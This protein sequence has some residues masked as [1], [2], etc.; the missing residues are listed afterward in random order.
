M[1]LRSCHRRRG[2]RE[3]LIVRLRPALVSFILLF[4]AKSDEAL[5]CEGVDG[6]V[7]FCPASNTLKLDSTAPLTGDVVWTFQGKTDSLPGAA[8]F[9]PTTGKTT[10]LT[11]PD[12][13]AADS[14]M[15]TATY[16]TNPVTVRKFSILVGAVT[17]TAA[18][19]C[20][21]VTGSSI[22]MDSDGSGTVTWVHTAPSATATTSITDGTKFSDSNLKAMGLF[23][24]QAPNAGTYKASYGEV[25]KDFPVVVKA[26][27]TAVTIQGK[28]AVCAGGTV[29][30]ECKV[31]GDAE[32]VTWKKDNDPTTANVNGKDL[33]ISAAQPEDAAKYT[34][35]AKSYRGGQP[36]DS[37]DFALTVSA[38]VDCEK[39][40]RGRN[41]ST[42]IINSDEKKGTFGA[43]RAASR[44]VALLLMT[45][46]LQLCWML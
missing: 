7:K 44:S 45:S 15:Y 35:R 39:P 14:G 25:S 43:A 10:T 2:R 9:G 21:V 32:E 28:A 24:V 22:V 42:P 13:S 46:L 12:L 33:T 18:T 31:G 17:C 8:T 34:C 6:H 23:N 36:A 41:S 20:N 30:L 26:R 38:A 29:S 11:L 19:P 37:P 5:D 3:P 1:V 4:L 40:Q 16:G 27:V